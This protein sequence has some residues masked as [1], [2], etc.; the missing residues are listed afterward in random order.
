MALGKLC[1]SS[2][3]TGKTRRGEMDLL[4]RAAI[5]GEVKVSINRI[6]CLSLGLG[7]QAC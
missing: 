2:G 3:A 6:C 1:D 5:K 7:F 4:R